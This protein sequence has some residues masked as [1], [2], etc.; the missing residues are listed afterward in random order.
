MRLVGAVW[1]V[2]TDTLKQSVT[3]AAEAEE[4]QAQLTAALIAQGTALPQTID[5]MPTMARRCKPPHDF[6]TMPPTAR[7][8]CSRLS[9]M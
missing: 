4:S 1:E 5:P 3:S 9:A 8:R 6:R 2:F 7:C